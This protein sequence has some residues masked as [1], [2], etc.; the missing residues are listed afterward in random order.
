MSTLDALQREIAEVRAQ[1]SSGAE[2]AD[3]RLAA[4]LDRLE[5]L[6]LQLENLH[7]EAEVARTLARQQLSEFDA[8]R[9][10]RK[11]T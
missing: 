9:A 10:R 3:D 1:L 11:V 2:I 8:E 4:L 5:T 6:R 7:R